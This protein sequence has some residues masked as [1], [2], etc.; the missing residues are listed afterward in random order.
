M[1]FEAMAVLFMKMYH[2]IVQNGQLVEGEGKSAWNLLDDVSENDC[3]SDMQRLVQKI[4][5][6]CHLGRQ[7]KCPGRV[8]CWNGLQTEEMQR[9]T[10]VESHFPNPSKRTCMP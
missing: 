5:Y 10:N 4:M 1:A 7:A 6:V 3:E 8:A 9:I 2:E